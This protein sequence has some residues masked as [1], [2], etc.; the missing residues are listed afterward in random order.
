MLTISL[1][2]LSLRLV[3]LARRLVLCAC[4]AFLLLSA[5]YVLQYLLGYQPCHLCLKQ[6][7]VWWALLVCAA[8]PSCLPPPLRAKFVL[9]KPVLATPILL[10]S[11][12]AALLALAGGALAGFH[13]GGERGWWSLTLL[14]EG[15]TFDPAMTTEDLRALLLTQAPLPCDEP[16]LRVFGL[17]LS[18]YN[19]LFSFFVL[20]WLAQGLRRE[21]ASNSTK[22]RSKLNVE[23]NAL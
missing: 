11:L 17:S 18:E 7:I 14:C 3:P 1:Q 16:A 13:A 6:R 22:S 4:L 8:A 10:A 5:A 20:G 15:F 9:T 2:P 23:R 19:A 12:C 21:L